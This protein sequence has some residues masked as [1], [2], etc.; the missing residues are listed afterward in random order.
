MESLCDKSDVD[1]VVNAP[2]GLNNFLKEVSNL[3]FGKLKTV[4]VDL[5]KLIELLSKKV[6]K[7]TKFNPL[8]MKVNNLEKKIPDAST[9]IQINQ[10]N[11]DKKSLEKTIGHIDNKIPD[12][13]G[14]KTTTVLN[15]KI[16]E[17]ENKILGTSGLVTISILNTKNGEVENEISDVTGLVKKTDYNAKISDIEGKYFT[18]FDYE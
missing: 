9:L 5:E 11:I 8:N 10:Y 12:V 15:T 14:L 6:L 2:T 7:N 16:V 18:T 13:S 3:D 4:L 17:V 1:E